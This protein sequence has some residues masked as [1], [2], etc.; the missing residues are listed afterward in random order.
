MKKRTLTVSL[1]TFLMVGSIQMNAAEVP[2]G[3]WVR[4]GYELTVVED[5]IKKPR[6]M[7]LDKDGVL[8]VSVIAEGKILACRDKDGDGSYESV[9]PFIEGKDPKAGFKGFSF[10]TAGYIL[11]S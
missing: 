11:P 3:V 10:A 8:Y 4:D 7:A 2:E 6:F 9:T 1:S 5:T